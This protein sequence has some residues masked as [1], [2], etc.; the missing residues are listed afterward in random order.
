MSLEKCLYRC[1]VQLIVLILNYMSYLEIKP[2]SVAS[3]ENSFS[4]SVGVLLILSTIFL[5]EKN[6]YI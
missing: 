4:C 6:F 2:L 3:F 5:C 1:S